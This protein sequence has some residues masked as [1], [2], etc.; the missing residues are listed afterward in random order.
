MMLKIC[1]FLH[2]FCVQNQGNEMK[3]LVNAMTIN[4]MRYLERKYVE[5]KQA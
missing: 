5:R 3:S 4:A 1:D 2:H